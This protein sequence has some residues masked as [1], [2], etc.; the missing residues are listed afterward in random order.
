MSRKSLVQ[1]VV[2]NAAVPRQEVPEITPSVMD[3]AV[4]ARRFTIARMLIAL[5]ALLVG[6]L[7][8]LAYQ[9]YGRSDS[10]TVDKERLSFAT[11]AQGEFQ[12][13]IPL[14]GVLAPSDTVYLD[15]A[16][17]GQVAEVLVEE[18]AK[19]EAGQLLVKLKSTR[20]E[21]ELLT[22][23]TQLAE[24]V[25]QL[26]TTKLSY[27]QD[28]INSE[29]SVIDARS[30]MDKLLA[31][32]K[33]YEPLMQQGVIARSEY[34]NLNLDIARQQQ[35]L[36]SAEAA[37]S[38]SRE[39]GSAQIER[40]QNTVDN[41]NSKLE[42]YKNNLDSLNVRAPI[43]GQ[44]TSFNVDVGQAKPQGSRIGQIDRMEQT[45]VTASVDEFYLNR[46]TAGQMATAELDGKSYRFKVSKVYP[47]V[48][49]RLFKLEMVFVDAAPAGTR[50]GQ[51]LQLKLDIGGTSRALI[52]GNGAF[53]DAANNGVFV[54]EPSGASAER[55][56]VKLGRRNTDYVEV[57]EGLKAGEQVLISSYKSYKDI[58]HLRLR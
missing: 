35:L 55:R 5:L 56:V 2:A 33:R 11:V 16:E 37:L 12:E 50:V 3:R 34:E 52:V 24:Q 39:K 51:S 18:G 47:E 43:S 9:R 53:Y 49:D 57:L 32:Q 29:R 6:A 22:N 23:E 27:E 44:L 25:N 15:L 48:R 26:S 8:L 30:S 54:L 10:L 31:Q 58:N 21:L 45:K 40:M 42:I 4:Q 1:P 19:V 41:L 14:V 7:L 13:F 28:R 17:G 46:V 38:L 36:Q 20:L